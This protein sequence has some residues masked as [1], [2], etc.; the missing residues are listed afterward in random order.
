MLRTTLTASLL[1]LYLLP[2]TVVHAAPSPVPLLVEQC[3]RLPSIE[4]TNAF[5]ILKDR[6]VGALENDALAADTPQELSL[7]EQALVLEQQTIGLNN[8]NDR[9]KYY[10]SFNL[11]SEERQGLLQCQLHLADT[12]SNLVVQAEFKQLSAALSQGNREQVLLSSQLKALLSQHWDLNYKAKLHTA[13]ASIRQGLA[14]QQLSLDIQNVQCQLPTETQYN[15]GEIDLD[16]QTNEPKSADFSGTIAHYLLKQ[17]DPQCR[18]TVWQAYQGRASEYNQTALS[19]IAVLWQEAAT[20]A[21]FN[22]YASWRL[23]SQQLSSPT[24]VKAFL[25]SQ[26]EAINVAPW[27]LGRHLAML[28]AADGPIL[29]TQAILNGGFTYLATFGLKFEPL[30]PQQP[31]TLPKQQM[32]RVYHQQRLLGE[33]YIS[34]DEAQ[35]RNYQ[36]TL[37]QSVIGQQFGQQA[38]DLKPQLSS[39]KDIEQFTQAIAKAIT[40][41]ARGSHFYLNNTLAPTMDSNQLP[42]LWLAEVLRH[43]LFPQFA[44]DYLNERGSLAKAYAKQMKVFRAKVALD[45]PQ[46]LSTQSY[47]ELSAEFEKSFGQPWPQTNHYQYSFSAIVNEGPLYYQSLWQSALAQFVYQTTLN[48]QNKADLFQLLVVN[49]DALTLSSQLSACLGDP[50]DPASLIQRMADAVTEGQNQPQ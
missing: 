18:Q 6:K 9:L 23:N 37:R 20:A 13:Q 10:R 39:Y 38:L 14:S 5:A 45:F 11:S 4:L 31:G 12:L 25:D 1:S 27:D 16:E 33:L 17:T 8:I 30:H 50:I 3:L 42:S 2:A 44:A 22:D 34:F 32:V 29:S 19:R 47:P 43:Q 48:T 41:L 35:H 24:L 46:D 21:G 15:T 36:Q 40:A 49:E 28:D 26:T 7:A